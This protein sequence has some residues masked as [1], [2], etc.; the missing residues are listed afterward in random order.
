MT[1]F[2]IDGNRKHAAIMAISLIAILTVGVFAIPAG[3]QILAQT[4]NQTTSGGLTDLA[5][6]ATSTNQTSSNTTT[7]SPLSALVANATTSIANTSSN[8]TLDCNGI[9]ALLGSKIAVPNGNVCDVVLVRGSPQVVDSN[10]MVQNKFTLMNTVIEFT[11]VSNRTGVTNTTSVSVVADFALLESE[12]KPVLQTMIADGFQ[13][14]GYHNHMIQETPKMTFVHWRAHGTLNTIVSDIKQALAK[15]TILTTQ[16]T[17]APA[18]S[19]T[20]DCNAIASKLGSNIS[21]RN[22][23]VCDVV[24]VRTSPQIVDENGTALNI[25][26][27]MN[28]VI[29]FTP[30]SNTMTSSVATNATSIPMIPSNNATTSNATITSGALGEI[31]IPSMSSNTS[32]TTNSTTMN[33]TSTSANLTTTSSTNTTSQQVMAMGDFALLESEVNPVLDV[34]V[35]ANWTV[36]GFHNHMLQENPKLSFMHWTAQGTL[37]SVINTANAA[38]DHTTIPHGTTTISSISPAPSTETNSTSSSG[39]NTTTT[40][41]GNTTSTS[42]NSTGST[43]SSSASIS[44]SGGNSTVTVTGTGFAPDTQVTTTINGDSSTATTTKTTTAG[45]FDSSLLVSGMTGTLH[46]VSKASDGTEASA[47]ITR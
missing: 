40:T 17:A 7:T 33:S 12:V 10:G 15:T 21:V 27:L 18:K 23:D 1:Y 34:I 9:A 35:P 30:A 6:N 36:T 29:E 5:S 46:I 38:L 19:T 20:L 28:S 32:S 43:S 26:T 3:H 14:T 13:I 22:G 47:D 16:P 37:E 31:A 39:V 24:L 4:T 41:T 44:V 25:F 8:G 11:P 2:N 42:S 45:T